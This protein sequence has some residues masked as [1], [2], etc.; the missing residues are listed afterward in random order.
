[1]ILISKQVIRLAAS[2]TVNG[3]IAGPY[4]GNEKVIKLGERKIDSD[5]LVDAVFH[6]KWKSDAAHH[7]DGYQASRINIWRDYLPQYLFEKMKGRQAGERFEVRLRNG[8]GVPQFDKKNLLQIKSTQFDRPPTWDVDQRPVI[9]RFYPKGALKNIAGIYSE[10]IQPFRCVEIKN[11]H[12][13]VDL[14]HPLSGK[15]LVISAVIGKVDTK[16]TER[17]GSSIDWMEELGNGP[18]MQARWRGQRTD[19]FSGEAFTR[20]D[21]SPDSLFYRQPRLVQHIDDTAIEMCRNTYERF[22][23]ND[24]DVLDLMSS[25][26]SHLP[27]KLNFKRIVG[28]GLNERELKNNIQ[29][30]EHLVQDLN[31]KTK[32]PF[33]SQTFDAVICSVSIEYLI[34]PLEI[35]KE[36]SRILRTDGY[37]IVTFSNRW[38]PTKAIRVWKELHEFERMGMVL[39]YFIRSKSFKNL[40]TYSIRGLPRPH[41]DKYFPDLRFSDPV[42]VVWGQK[43]RPSVTP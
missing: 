22:L 15:E 34:K 41:S 8:E 13:L 7:T 43:D 39:E 4:C 3:A 38:F 21:E 23:E 16:G 29:I 11:G 14:N 30:T 37:F 42:Y 27:R 6:L 32:L 19:F 24:M 12:M 17:G 25:W 33:D 20:D 2:M 31:V 40:Q 5:S 35:F 1:M 26:Q 18:G 10:N 9:G 28:I 36:V